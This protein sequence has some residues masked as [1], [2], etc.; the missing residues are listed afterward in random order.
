VL[1]L[2]RSVAEPAPALSPAAVLSRW[3]SETREN[4]LQP[5]LLRLADGRIVPLPVGRW[6]GPASRADHAL[7]DRA[8]GPVLDLGCG[9]GRLTAELHT[10]GTDVLGVELLPGV[11]VLAAQVGAPVLEGDVF[12]PLPRTG[13]W[14]TVLLADGN[15]GIGGDP[16]RLLR[17][18]RMLLA[19]D[20]ELLCELHP[21]AGCSGP[22]RLEGLGAT[23]E[24][25]RWT[26][27]DGAGLAAAATS[28][29]LVVTDS[30]DEEGR[31]FAALR[32]A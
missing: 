5:R 11:P 13:R 29:G 4:D 21:E 25:F 32:A 30:W 7:L 24:W 15:I 9:P 14:Q 1:P 20:G 18:V 12:G 2:V 6:T 31:P 8:L 3:M 27:L 17:R 26:L 19:P 10:R 16:V 22:V 23:S 28:A